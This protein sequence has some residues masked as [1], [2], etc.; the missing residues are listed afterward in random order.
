[1]E[2]VGFGSQYAIAER[3]GGEKAGIIINPDTSVA[4]HLGPEP[5]PGNEV[6]WIQTIPGKGFWVILRLY[7]PLEPWFDNTWRSGEIELT[8]VGLAYPIEHMSLS[9]PQGQ[10]ELR[11]RPVESPVTAGGQLDLDPEVA[12]VIGDGKDVVVGSKVGLARS[13]HARLR[14]TERADSFL[15][16]AL[17]EL[18]AVRAELA[19]HFWVLQGPSGRKP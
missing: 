6:D 5:P 4:T 7:G 15:L 17:H 11:P 1:M 8:R 13:D 10:F 9:G 18:F 14:E 19:V 16:R 3:D 12:T 2:R